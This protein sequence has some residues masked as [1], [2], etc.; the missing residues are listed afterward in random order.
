M[1]KLLALVLCVMMFVSV[2]PTSAFAHTYGDLTVDNPLYSKAQYAD[3]I[4]NMIKNTKSNIEGSYKVLVGDQVVYGSAKAMDDIIVGLVDGIGTTLIEKD[5][6]TKAAVDAVKDNVRSYFDT[7]VAKKISDN[8][9]KAYD[10]DGKKDPLLY[11]QLVANSIQDA[12]TD[13]DF[14]KGYEAVVTFWALAS[15]VKDVQDDLKDARKDFAASVDKKFQADFAA[16][17]DELVDDYI[18]TFATAKDKAEAN[19]IA[20]LA[21]DA[22]MMPG[23][24]AYATAVAAANTARNTALTNHESWLEAREAQSA[25]DTRANETNLKLA[26]LAYDNVM[27]DP[28][29]SAAD[30]QQ[31]MTDYAQACSDYATESERIAEYDKATAKQDKIDVKAIQAEYNK[32]IRDAEYDHAVATIGAE[33][34]WIAAGYEF[35]EINPWAASPYS[36]LPVVG[37]WY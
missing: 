14:Q 9:Y 22:L 21:L 3:Q 23:D 36:G 7:A 30:K 11:A 10:K 15:M 6:L 26:K 25:A 32:S 12:L 29:A 34:E 2:I 24:N 8:M 16:K 27:N 5:S 18:D 19:A 20:Q 28:T 31:A 4:K 37:N 33:E 35:E 13:Q 17:Y 1:K